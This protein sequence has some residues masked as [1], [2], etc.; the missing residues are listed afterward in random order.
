MKPENVLLQ[1]GQ[2]KIADFGFSRFTEDSEEIFM[3]VTLLGSPLYMAPQILK[4]QP[5]TVKCDIWSLGIMFY[6]ML[7]AVFP[8]P[9]NT[10]AQLIHNIES[11]SLTFPEYPAIDSLT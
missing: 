2:A 11:K 4:K 3:M 5:Y 7:F 9:A 1:N 8:W 10:P 6:Q